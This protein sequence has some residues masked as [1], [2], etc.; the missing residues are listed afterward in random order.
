MFFWNMGV[1]YILLFA[2]VLS[3][4]HRHGARSKI[5]TSCDSCPTVSVTQSAP[6]ALVVGELFA[7]QL[8]ISVSGPAS[9]PFTLKAVFSTPFV[10]ITA[11]KVTGGGSCVIS[12]ATVTC[13]LLSQTVSNSVT[14]DFF[15]KPEF[16]ENVLEAAV[17]SSVFLCGK[18]EASSVLSMVAKRL[19]TGCEGS[20]KRCI[21]PISWAKLV[22]S[23]P[24]CGSSNTSAVCVV[25]QYVLIDSGSIVAPFVSIIDSGILQ[26]VGSGSNISFQAHSILVESGGTFRVGFAD[27]PFG[28]DGSKLE[29]GIYGSPVDTAITCQTSATCGVPA[30]LWIL[31]WSNVNQSSMLPGSVDLFYAYMNFSFPSNYPSLLYNYSSA[32]GNPPEGFFGKKVFAVSYGATVEMYGY[33]G[34]GV[35]EFLCRLLDCSSVF[36]QG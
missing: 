17:S 3:L 20:S 2:F 33:S 8:L 15:V 6:T 24:D 27:A 9:A 18:P 12:G 1:F 35:S 7:R 29:I 26:F 31:P 22:E 10:T 23:K 21:T 36:H 25:D 34:V 32:Q 13:T 16:T 5:G 28:S 19:R 30:S 14:V 11:V 4:G